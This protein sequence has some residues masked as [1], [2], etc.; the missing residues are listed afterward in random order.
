M[1]RARL[2]SRL[3]CSDFL[4]YVKERHPPGDPWRIRAFRGDPTA[5]GESSD[6]CVIVV[7]G[8]RFEGCCTGWAAGA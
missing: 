4:Y 3:D 1:G 7:V 6:L 8:R 2:G 5:L